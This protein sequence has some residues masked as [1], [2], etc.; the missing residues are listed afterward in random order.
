MYP[1]CRSVWVLR[2]CTHATR[3]H[4]RQTCP[5][6]PRTSL[7]AAAPPRGVHPPAQSRDGR[8]SFPVGGGHLNAPQA[9]NPTP[10]PV[11]P[12]V[13]SRRPR[14][15]IHALPRAPLG[16]PALTAVA[17]S[18]LSPLG[19]CQSP[20]PRTGRPHN[21]NRPRPPSHCPGRRQQ[22]GGWVSAISHIP[23]V[24]WRGGPPASG[25]RRLIRLA[26][27]AFGG[28]R[29]A[30]L[31][32]SAMDQ[33]EECLSGCGQCAYKRRH[34]AALGCDAAPSPHLLLNNT[35][36]CPHPFAQHSPAPFPFHRPTTLCSSPALHPP[37]RP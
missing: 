28:S 34:A 3:I 30:P 24:Q 22:P 17:H 35:G 16:R 5:K 13:P 23:T 29:P 9:C 27:S 32:A 1:P 11:L 14:R 6:R 33:A 20:C 8:L 12:P 2:P 19:A 25:T 37:N 15:G 21:R 36:L 31:R 26:S 7:P 18:L 4:K 10:S